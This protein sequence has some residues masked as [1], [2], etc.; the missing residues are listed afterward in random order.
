MTG[1][2]LALTAASCG[3]GG[4]SAAELEKDRATYLRK[5]APKVGQRL[6]QRCRSEVEPFV[7]ELRDLSSRLTIGLSYLDYTTRVGDVAVAHGNV[8][9]GSL[10]AKCLEAASVAEEGLEF[11]RIAQELWDLCIDIDNCEVPAI[12]NGLQTAWRGARERTSSAYAQL[13]AIGTGSTLNRN[14]PLS[15]AGVTTS[16]YG[17]VVT[18][19]C[20]QM[21]TDDAR[22]ACDDL[23]AVLESGIDD[24][25]SSDLNQA[26]KSLVEATA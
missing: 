10:D 9:S 17:A 7:Q 12:K 5:L 13:D 2:L 23:D 18:Y 26:L 25:E 4:P 1:A 20:P 8:E 11:H 15:Q 19:L 21:D 24:N 3:G 22:T 14:L 6:E 16:I